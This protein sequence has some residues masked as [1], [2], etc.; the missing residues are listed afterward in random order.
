METIVIWVLMVELWTDPPPKIQIVYKKEY[1]TREECMQAREE[2]LGKK[3]E[4]MCMV[5]V[6][7]VNSVGK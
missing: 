4:A 7:N 3:L 6:K 5:K 1:A 2:W